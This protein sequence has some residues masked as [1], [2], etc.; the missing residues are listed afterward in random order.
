MD[1]LKLYLDV[2]VRF[3]QCVN[4]P[5]LL[6]VNIGFSEYAD[7]DFSVSVCVSVHAGVCVCLC[8]CTP[9]ACTLSLRQRFQYFIMKFQAEV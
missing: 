8:V 1:Q 4:G 3:A 7:G 9:G 6:R 2:F 5:V